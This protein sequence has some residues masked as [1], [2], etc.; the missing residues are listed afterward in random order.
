MRGRRPTAGL[1]RHRA[2][3]PCYLSYLYLFLSTRGRNVGSLAPFPRAEMANS[4]GVAG[5]S[6]LLAAG[7]LLCWR[8]R[9]CCETWD[10]EMLPDRSCVHTVK[11][12]LPTALYGETAIGVLN[13]WVA[14]MEL[15]CCGRIQRAIMERARH[16]TFG[17]TLQ[18]REAWEAAGRWL[19][20]QQA[21]QVATCADMH[22]LPQLCRA[23]GRT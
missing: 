17:Y 20:E 23:Y 9:R 15:A 22:T 10:F 14:D 8:R 2:T 5:I 19:F 6:S 18:P 13:M 7:L 4:L 11:H 16:N 12:E 21:W 1:R 3:R